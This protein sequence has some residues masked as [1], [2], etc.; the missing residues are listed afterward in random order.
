MKLGPVGP[1]HVLRVE[2]LQSVGNRVGLAV[3]SP[4][5]KGQEPGPVSEVCGNFTRGG[6]FSSLR[7][8]R[9]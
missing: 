6:N 1:G 5:E 2:F 9:E 8:L 3:G 4:D 7:P